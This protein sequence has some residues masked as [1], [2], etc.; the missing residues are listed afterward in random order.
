M[1]TYIYI[2]ISL[3][4]FA[5]PSRRW[6]LL[7]SMSICLN[8]FSYIKV[9]YDCGWSSGRPTYSSMLNDLTYLNESSPFLWYLENARGLMSREL[10]F[11]SWGF[12]YSYLKYRIWVTACPSCG[13]SVLKSREL[14]F[15][16]LELYSYPIWL[17]VFK[18]QLALLVVSGNRKLGARMW[19]VCCRGPKW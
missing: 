15:G 16:S 17:T 14:R 11:G 4:T 6:V 7:G 8:R 10:R 5:L 9:W 19:E 18:W 1:Y 2:C 13:I 12:I 3:H